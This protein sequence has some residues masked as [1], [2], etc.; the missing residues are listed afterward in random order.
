MS[1]ELKTTIGATTIDSVLGKEEKVEKVEKFKPQLTLA[2]TDAATMRQELKQMHATLLNSALSVKPAEKVIPAAKPVAASVTS[3]TAMRPKVPVPTANQNLSLVQA[4]N[5]FCKAKR[6]YDSE[7]KETTSLA[8]S[9]SMGGAKRSPPIAITI[10]EYGRL[11]LE[12]SLAW[13]EAIM[14]ERQEY[15]VKLIENLNA[16]HSEGRSIFQANDRFLPP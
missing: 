7:G 5:I 3:A 9:S 2:T 15:F 8:S 4:R 12:L 13:R 10:G 6:K 14:P 1:V 16:E 11:E